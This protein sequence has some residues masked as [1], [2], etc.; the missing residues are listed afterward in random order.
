MRAMKSD[1]GSI[2]LSVPPTAT[3]RAPVSPALAAGAIEVRGNVDRPAAPYRGQRRAAAGRADDQRVEAAD[4]VAEA[5]ADLL[6][7][8]EVRAR[9]PEQRRRLLPPD[10]VRA[11]GDG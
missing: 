10:P 5:D 1:S 11:G 3:S 2:Q 4:D 6:A 8:A 9:R 7:V